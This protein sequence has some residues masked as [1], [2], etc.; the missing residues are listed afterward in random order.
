MRIS[1]IV[2]LLTTMAT[3]TNAAP[4]QELSVKREMVDC[5]WDVIYQNQSSGGSPLISDCLQIAANIV[6]D[7]EW[8]IEGPGFNF[9][10]ENEDIITIINESIRQ[11]Q[12]F[13]KR[14]DGGYGFWTDR[15]PHKCHLKLIFKYMSRSLRIVEITMLNR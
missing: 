7:G 15:L 5:C 6:R 14:P 1:N 10:V 9:R 8:I 2:A 4:S 12:W 11:F 13:D 3:L